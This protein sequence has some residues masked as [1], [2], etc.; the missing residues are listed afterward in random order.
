MVIKILTGRTKG[1]IN[2][3]N[4]IYIDDKQGPTV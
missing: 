2:W 3:K 4:K 1:G